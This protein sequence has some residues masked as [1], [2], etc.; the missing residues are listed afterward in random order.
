MNKSWILHYQRALGAAQI[1]V[2]DAIRI[3]DPELIRQ[4]TEALEYLRRYYRP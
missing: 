4:R 1:A 3:G 2:V